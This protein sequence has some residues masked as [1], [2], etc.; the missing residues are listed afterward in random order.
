MIKIWNSRQGKGYFSY[1]HKKKTS[2]TNAPSETRSQLVHRDKRRRIQ[3]K[4]QNC[5][6]RVISLKW[7]QLVC[8]ASRSSQSL[9]LNIYWQV[10][11]SSRP[12]QALMIQQGKL[13]LNS[14][15]YLSCTLEEIYLFKDDLERRCAYIRCWGKFWK[16]WGIQSRNFTSTDILSAAQHI[17]PNFIFQNQNIRISNDILSA[18]I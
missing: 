17:N 8:I 10:L 18:Q 7:F 16:L 6:Q 14:S 4:T 13:S 2:K 9:P 15:S 3:H 12:C 11:S 5:A 1:K